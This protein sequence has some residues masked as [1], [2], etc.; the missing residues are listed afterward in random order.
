VIET[1]VS[2]VANSSIEQV[3]V[4]PAG[5][6]VL[7]LLKANGGYETHYLHR[8]AVRAGIARAS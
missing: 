4:D 1:E 3:F 8:C 5:N 2:R 7:L 6:H